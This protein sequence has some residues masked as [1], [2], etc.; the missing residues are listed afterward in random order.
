MNK[1]YTNFDLMRGLAILGVILIHITTDMI[2]NSNHVITDRISLFINQLMRFSVPVFFFLSGFGLTLS[3]KLNEGYITFLYKRL[4]SIIGL[5]S[6]W[7]LIYYFFNYADFHIV[8]FL[9]LFVLGMNYYHL[10]FVPL[11]IFCYILFPFLKKIA[12]TTIGIVITL[13]IMLL[14]QLG[15]TLTGFLIFNHPSN[16]FN[17]IFYFVLGIWFCKGID[18]K[19]NFIKKNG[20]IFKGAF[21]IA[22]TG[23]FIESSLTMVVL[24][25]SNSTTT[26]RPSV[27]LF[28]L[29]FIAVII[30][31]DLKN[32]FI[33][34]ILNTLSKWS[35]SMYLSHVLVLELFNYF[36]FQLSSVYSLVYLILGLII[37]T[38]ISL[39]VS[40]G[41]QAIIR[42]LTS[43]TRKRKKGSI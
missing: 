36:Y 32:D 21:I 8:T 18:Y 41:T 5:Y 14:S 10:Y 40:I 24:G 15:T 25:T 43:L 2:G 22:V 3:N 33:K 19:V 42:C 20:K 16:I 23:L 38:I 30:G 28:S 4:G 12:E 11:I 17:W 29:L 6:I 13:I 34:M 27:I 7:S 35:Y 26:M 1:R 37:V 39:L 31:I 9:K